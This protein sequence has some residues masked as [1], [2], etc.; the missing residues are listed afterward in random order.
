MFDLRKI[1]GR[2]L[3]DNA[4]YALRFLP[5]KQYLSFVY[6]LTT[7]KRI[8]F[9]NP[10]GY[11]EKLQWLKINQINPEY[12]KLVDKLRVREHIKDVWGEEHLFPLLGFW[13][14]FDDIDFN[15]LPN[16]FVLKCNHDSGSVKIIKDKSSLTKK[17]F[18]ELSKHF[19]KKLKRNGFYPAREYP[20]KNLEHYIFAE[21]FMI[22]DKNTEKSIEDYKFFCFNGVPQF[23]YVVTDRSNG[24]RNDFFDM[25]YNHLDVYYNHP[26]ADGVIEK[27]V[28]FDE[29][30][31]IA[32]RLSKG[33]KQVRIDL[34][35]I[36][37]KLYFGEYTFFHGGGFQLFKPEEWEY[38]F[39]DMIN[40]D[41]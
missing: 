2:N 36:N 33:L 38:K 3:R 15:K 27:P 9:N 19:K 39:G 32:T 11:N 25:N 8:N 40:L 34:Y 23:M 16:Q 14:S 29:M 41:L 18:Q 1:F 7:G 10:K 31:E 20:Y 21:K 12:S 30:V 28:L 13:K 37:G 22:N 6:Y 24:G 4:M 26:N 17:D 5:D 35:E